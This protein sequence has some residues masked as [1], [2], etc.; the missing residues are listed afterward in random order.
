MSASGDTPGN[1]AHTSA[2]LLAVDACFGGEG[3]AHVARADGAGECSLRFAFSFG[4]TDYHFMRTVGR[5]DRL[6][7]CDAE[8]RNPQEQGLD[9]FRAWLKAQYRLDGIDL[10]FRQIVGTYFRFCGG[11]HSPRSALRAY[12]MQSKEQQIRAFERLFEKYAPL[13]AAMEP[14]STKN[15]P[16]CA[17]ASSGSAP[18]PCGSNSPRTPPTR[19]APPRAAGLART[20]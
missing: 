6:F 19:S 16:R 17:G 11:R 10:P 13:Q 3:L 5:S 4:G 8:Y 9:A 1:A 18:P 14:P 12:F 2:L 20:A 7:T 15:L